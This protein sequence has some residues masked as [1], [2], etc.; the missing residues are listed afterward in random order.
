M[1]QNISIWLT[2][3]ISMVGIKAFAYDIEVKNEDGIKER[4]IRHGRQTAA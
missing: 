1:K 3:L 2:I 4:E